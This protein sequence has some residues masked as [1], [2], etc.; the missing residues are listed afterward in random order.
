MSDQSI[1]EQTIR[2]LIA[3]LK[4]A[5][6]RTLALV[7]G[8]DQQQII[9]P[10]LDIVNPLLWEIGHAA[11]FHELWTLRHL[12]GTDSLLKNADELYDSI[13]I[14]HEDRWDLPLLPLIETKAYMQQ[15]L[16]AE[17]DRL[18]NRKVT[19]QDIY[20][21][22][23]AV[24]HEDMHTEAYTYSRR[25]LNYPAP[26]FAN[27]VADDDAYNAGPLSGDVAIEGGEFLLGANKQTG[28]CFDNEKWQHPVDVKPFA[29]ARAATSYQQYAEFVDDGSYA[30]R[31]FWD[32]DAWQWLQNNNVT[33]PN[34]WRKDSA[35]NWLIKYF[36]S[37][38]AMQPH[39]AVIHINWFEACAW[40][41]WAGRRLP[42]EAEWELAASGTPDNI[43]AKRPYPWGDEAITEKRANMNSR[44]MRTIDVGALPNGDSAFGCRQM[45]GN[46]WEWTADTFQPYPGF[47][48][49]MYQ[50]YSQPLF[51]TTKVLRGGAWPT[52]SRMIRNS[53]RNYYGAERNDVFAGFRSCAL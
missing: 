45:L 15:V 18:S 6:R 22:R 2:T 51:G 24:C 41:R 8:L 26:V 3:D 4:D 44:A 30:N 27:S 14:A 10:K 25:S 39:A 29:I 34:G 17:I 48:A 36:D 21:T 28:F 11:Y 13:N 20:L 49:D 19:A 53:W 33:V 16:D 47:T 12:D 52:R 46:A 9:G 40:C 32:D 5:R 31:Q 50:D 23:Y 43:N 35:G 37:W 7:D 42:T 1:S 38:T